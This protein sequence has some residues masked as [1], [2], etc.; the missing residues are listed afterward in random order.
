[1]RRRDVV[2]G[3]MASSVLAGAA[4]ALSP[5]EMLSDPGL[6][7]RARQLDHEIRCVK[8]QSE[9]VASSNASW[10][11]DARRSIRELISN[12]ASNDDVK[13]WFVERYGEFVL[14]DPAKTGSNLALWLAGPAMLLIALAGAIPYIR[15]RSKGIERP[16]TA[17]LNS[18]EQARLAE[19]LKD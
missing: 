10:A 6:E 15:G 18:Q 19:I 4:F 8:C 2:W 12:G 13:T 5:D 14:M 17:A 16:E 3:L 1:M 7:A 9:S 11:E